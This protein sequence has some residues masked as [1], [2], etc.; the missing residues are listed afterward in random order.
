MIMRISLPGF[1]GIVLPRRPCACNSPRLIAVKKF[2]FDF[3]RGKFDHFVSFI[4]LAS[5]AVF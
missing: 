3:S 4:P 1:A 2:A 5:M